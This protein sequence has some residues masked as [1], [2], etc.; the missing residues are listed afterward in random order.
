MLRKKTE[1]AGAIQRIYR[2]RRLISKAG[3]GIDN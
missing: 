1:R 3:K 2:N